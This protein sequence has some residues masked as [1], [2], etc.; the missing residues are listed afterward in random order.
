[1]S[2]G[3]RGGARAADRRCSRRPSGRRERLLDSLAAFRLPTVG[4]NIAYSRCSSTP[5]AALPTSDSP[6]SGRGSAKPS[7]S[8]RPSGLIAV[9]LSRRHA[10]GAPRS[11]VALVLGRRAPLYESQRPGYDPV[12]APSSSTTSF[13]TSST[14]SGSRR[15]VVSTTSGAPSS[16]PTGWRSCTSGASASVDR[17]ERRAPRATRSCTNS[18]TRPRGSTRNVPSGFLVMAA[19]VRPDGL[20]SF[21]LGPSSAVWSGN[22]VR[23]PLHADPAG[24]QTGH[25]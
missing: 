17:R 25:R 2:A 6:G 8:N 22:P 23:G 19:I 21:S 5:R 24:L 3:A 15:S 20:T 14:V 11:R 12:S 1:M 9:R 10:Q 7:D 4:E 18:C 13:A 16:S